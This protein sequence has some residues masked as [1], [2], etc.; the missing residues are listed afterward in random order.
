M[1]LRLNVGLSQKVGESNYG[2]RGA[3]VNIEM[4]LEAALVS[5]PAKLQERIRQLFA[6]VRASLTEELRSNGSGADQH[7]SCNN[8]LAKDAGPGGNAEI[9]Q[10]GGATRSQVRAIHAI[11]SKQGI[12][13]DQLLQN[14]Y[15]TDRPDDL[16][17]KQASELIDSLKSSKNKEEA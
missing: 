16:T 4:E 7:G 3:S 10:R 14:R 2:S 17:I 1:P 5:E 12:H 13:I 9:R 11:A 6:I 8:G 15:Q